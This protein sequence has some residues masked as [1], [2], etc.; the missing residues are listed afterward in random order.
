MGIRES[1]REQPEADNLKD[2]VIEEETEKEFV[3]MFDAREAWGDKGG[4]ALVKMF[5]ARIWSKDFPGH[6]LKLGTLRAVWPEKFGL[7]NVDSEEKGLMFQ[8]FE[9][10]LVKIDLFD[11]DDGTYSNV[12]LVGKMLVGLYNAFPDDF[13]K[14]AKIIDS[15][16]S[17]VESFLLSGFQRSGRTSIVD[18]CL[19]L[20]AGV[21]LFLPEKFSKRIKLDDRS[22]QE[23]IAWS[24]YDEMRESVEYFVSYLAYVRLAFPDDFKKIKITQS[25]WDSINW[26][27]KNFKYK[28]YSQDAISPKYAWCLDVIAAKEIK[29]ENGKLKIIKGEDEI[30]FKTKK[31]ERPERRN[32]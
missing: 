17:K 8:F 7:I 15:Q 6:V 26:G 29:F 30:G 23:M 10:Y 27:A 14:Y 4:D 12:P 20:F 22:R 25:N 1:L 9:Q 2:F 24:Q 19:K 31:R 16:W 3:P 32:F 13:D 21:K 11:F 18:D 5:D 28:D